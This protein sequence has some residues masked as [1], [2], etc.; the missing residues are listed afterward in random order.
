MLTP[1]SAG[2]VEIADGALRVSGDS[3]VFN[4][5]RTDVAPGSSS[6]AVIVEMRSFAGSQG[7]PQDTLF[8]GLI[9]DENNYV[10]IRYHN[11]LKR[12]GWDLV[13]DG[14]LVPAGGESLAA[15]EGEVDL[16]SPGSRYAFVSRD[17]TFT[18]YSDEGRGWEYL[19]TVDIGGVLDLGDPAVLS[20]YRYGFG[21]RVTSGTVSL[22]GV[23]ARSR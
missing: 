20:G 22:E 13:Q 6:A 3:E 4:L 10:L 23:E 15:L 18:A 17:K 8:A 5:F 7:D 19:F 14:R 2:Q 16:S 12:S 21:V 9:K 1:T 11:G